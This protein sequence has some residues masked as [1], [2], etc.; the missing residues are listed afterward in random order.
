MSPLRYNAQVVQRAAQRTR[1][2]RWLFNTKTAAKCRTNAKTARRRRYRSD[3]LGCSGGLTAK[4]KIRRQR[5]IGDV[6]N[7][8]S[9]KGD[10]LVEQG[11]TV[12]HER[13]QFACLQA[14]LVCKGMVA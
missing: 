12:R 4:E 11:Q 6:E 10:A 3:W 14:R 8:T 13:Q 2:W 7:E 1:H 9:Y 5:L